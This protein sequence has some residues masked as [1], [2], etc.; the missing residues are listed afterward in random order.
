HVHLFRIPAEPLVD[1]ASLSRKGLIGFDE[2]EIVDGPASLGQSLLG[3]GDWTGTQNG[4]INARMGPG[5]DACERRDAPLLRFFQRHQHDSGGAVVDAR[6]IAG[7]HRA[8]LLERRAQLGDGFVG[9]T[10]ADV[11]VLGDDRLAFPG[12]D[13]YGS[14]LV[15]ELARLLGSLGL[16]LRGDREPVLLLTGDLPLAG[17]S[18]E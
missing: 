15:L 10:L 3:G 16:V 2:V 5:D 12:Y 6:G 17:R 9:G 14:D 11:L 1:G 7:R 4:R 18:E 13:R 8:V